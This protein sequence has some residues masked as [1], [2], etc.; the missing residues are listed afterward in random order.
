MYPVE[1]YLHTLKLYVRNKAQPDGSIA[2][3]YTVSEFMTLCSRY[4]NEIETK[5]N[6]LERNYDNEDNCHEK[7]SIFSHPG[8]PI[9]EAK[10]ND[11]DVYE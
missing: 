11:M 7:L 1:R 6:H 5:F 10:C 3:G 9:G 2:E 8:G 4:L